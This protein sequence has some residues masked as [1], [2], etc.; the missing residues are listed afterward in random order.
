MTG[1]LPKGKGVFD[2][3][4]GNKEIIRNYS[5]ESIEDFVLYATCVWANPFTISQKIEFLRMDRITNVNYLLNQYI[6]THLFL[7]IHLIPESLSEDLKLSS[8]N[9]FAGFS[10]DIDEVFDIVHGDELTSE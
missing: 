9:C 7:Y 4:D 10:G 3:R 1:H 2:P 5:R 6:C 8:E